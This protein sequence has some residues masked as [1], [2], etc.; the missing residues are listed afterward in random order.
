MKHF[1]AMLADEVSVKIICGPVLIQDFVRLHVE[2][3]NAGLQPVQDDG[4]PFQRVVGGLPACAHE[5]M[6][7]HFRKNLKTSEF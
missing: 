3:V 5:I 1:P 4:K 7:I 2:N 6:F